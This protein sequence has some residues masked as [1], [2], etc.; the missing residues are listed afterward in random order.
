M[1]KKKKKSKDICSECHGLPAL[2]NIQFLYCIF[3]LLVR[4]ILPRGARTDRCKK[5]TVLVNR[6]S[7]FVLPSGE[8][9]I[10]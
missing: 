10:C 8:I 9:S 2:V 1:F 4:L 6:K 7:I 5:K 3:F